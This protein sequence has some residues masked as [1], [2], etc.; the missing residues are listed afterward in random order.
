MQIFSFGEDRVKADLHVGNRRRSGN[1]S[2]AT[3]Q[4]LL[5]QLCHSTLNLAVM[6]DA[7]FS[8]NDVVE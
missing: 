8:F 4:A 7:V 1:V 3:N 6:H 2:N 5:T